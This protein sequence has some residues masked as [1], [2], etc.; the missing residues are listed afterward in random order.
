MSSAMK[1][2]EQH[3]LYQKTSKQGKH[4]VS[5]I[6]TYCHH[7]RRFL[8][9]QLLRHN[10]CLCLQLKRAGMLTVLFFSA[11]KKNKTPDGYWKADDTV[12]QWQS[13]RQRMLLKVKQR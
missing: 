10:I 4:V 12:L 3:Y 5:A 7:C 8:Y 1:G 2:A 13:E 9:L 11:Y 6:K